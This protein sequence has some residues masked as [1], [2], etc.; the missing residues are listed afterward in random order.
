MFL[1]AMMVNRVVTIR[2]SVKNNIKYMFGSCKKTNIDE[3]MIFSIIYCTKNTEKLIAFVLC[4]LL[5]FFA[6]FA[7]IRVLYTR[8]HM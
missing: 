1:V 3:D 5:R 6:K 2:K 8:K 7:K 4:P